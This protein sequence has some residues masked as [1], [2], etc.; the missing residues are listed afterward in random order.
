MAFNICID[1]F[2]FPSSAVGRSDEQYCKW[3][4]DP[5]QL[6]ICPFC[7]AEPTDKAKMEVDPPPLS[8]SQPDIASSALPILTTM[9]E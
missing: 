3:L 6:F 4:A 8:G 7:F 5:P 9:T 2:S 1:F